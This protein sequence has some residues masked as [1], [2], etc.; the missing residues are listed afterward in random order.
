MF[1]EK[2][3]LKI[4]SIYFCTASQDFL[5][6]DNAAKALEAFCRER[7]CRLAVLMGRDWKEDRLTRDLAIY[8]LGVDRAANKVSGLA[9]RLSFFL[10]P[11]SPVFFF[12]SLIT[13]KTLCTSFS[14]LFHT[15]IFG[16]SL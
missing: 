8:S 1:R 13:Q 3:Y 6:L 2:C 10:H 11:Y 9:S 12:L 15:F 14:C 4:P 5:A 16:R 7:Q